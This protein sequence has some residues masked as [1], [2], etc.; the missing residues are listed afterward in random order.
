MAKAK[1]I[2]Y[3]EVTQGS[4][5]VTQAMVPPKSTSDQQNFNFHPNVLT[6]HQTL[7]HLSFQTL[8]PWWLFTVDILTL[9]KFATS[10]NSA[11][12]SC[13]RIASP[14]YGHD[15]SQSLSM[16]FPQKMEASP[17]RRPPWS[18]KRM[19]RGLGQYFFPHATQ[20]QCFTIF[21]KIG[22]KTTVWHRRPSSSKPR[23]LFHSSIP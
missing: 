4:N 17:T 1:G 18:G 15:C 16:S 5:L 22:D 2:H 9:D 23:N 7:A 19:P 21:T 20:N 3:R 12:L 13:Y 10:S 8:Q 11:P 14:N 6:C